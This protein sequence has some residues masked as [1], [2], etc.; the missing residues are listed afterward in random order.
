MDITINGQAKNLAVEKGTP[1]LWEIRDEVGSTGTKF[2]CGV[3]SCGNCIVHLDGKA[4]KSCAVY[5]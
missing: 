2:G 4:V 1:L 3:A 5:I